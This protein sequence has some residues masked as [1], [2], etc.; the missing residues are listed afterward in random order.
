M[1]IVDFDDTLLDTVAYKESRIVALEKIGVSRDIYNETYKQTYYAYTHEAHAA[2]LA[3]HGFSQD[4]VLKVL[5][6]CLQK[7]AQFIFP[8]TIDFLNF[9]K[10]H[11]DPII[12]LSFGVAN[13]QEFKVDALGIRH[14]FDK[15][16]TTIEPK[17]KALLALGAAIESG[18]WFFEDK[19]R[20]TL[21]V[22][23]TFP[24]F[25]IVLKQG[26]HIPEQEYQKS[27]LPHFKTLIEIKHYVREHYAK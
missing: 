25:R 13:I 5:N 26:T 3:T 23:N 18:S 27:G 7:V 6:E 8:D 16:V 14:Y 20:E 19:V 2:A 21:V 12:L 24:Q 9:L 1:F 11:K 10:S 22:H 4:A 17:E 15:I